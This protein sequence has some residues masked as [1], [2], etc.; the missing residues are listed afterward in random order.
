MDAPQVEPYSGLFSYNIHTN[1]WRRL[2]SD[3]DVF[4]GKPGLPSRMGHSMVFSQV[5]THPFT[6]R[7]SHTHMHTTA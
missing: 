7:R 1:V 2:L 5:A 6:H 4:G 3:R